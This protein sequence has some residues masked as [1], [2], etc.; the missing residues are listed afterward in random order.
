[1]YL[2][3]KTSQILSGKCF[4]SIFFMLQAYGMLVSDLMI[5][6]ETIHVTLFI[7]MTPLLKS[8]SMM[9][10]SPSLISLSSIRSLMLSSNNCI[11]VHC[12]G[13]AV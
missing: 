13:Q 5:I 11:M 7:T 9:V 12:N 3:S 8:M 2:Q 4:V 10:E 6:F 1:M